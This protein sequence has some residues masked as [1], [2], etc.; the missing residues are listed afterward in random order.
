M[1]NPN[2]LAPSLRAS[3][4]ARFKEL[5]RLEPGIVAYLHALPLEQAVVARMPVRAIGSSYAMDAVVRYDSPGVSRT[6]LLHVEFQS[7]AD[8]RMPQ[9]MVLYWQLLLAMCSA[10][11]GLQQ[12]VLRVRRTSKM[13][14]RLRLFAG[15]RTTVEAKVRALNDYDAAELALAATTESS[16]IPLAAALIPGARGGTS[17]RALSDS[18]KLLC[19]QPLDPAWLVHV[20]ALHRAL[21]E[22]NSVEPG[23]WRE[24]AMSI[25]PELAAIHE[26]DDAWFAEELEDAMMERERR[27]E[28][29]GREAGLQDGIK[30]GIEQGMQRAAQAERAHRQTLLRLAAACAPDLVRTLE[31]VDDLAELEARVL[32]AVQR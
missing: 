25:N 6:L 19:A 24:V 2:P 21:A 15:R 13:P 27:G 26:D 3:L 12:L 23:L 10:D 28:R 22:L 5:C 1:P 11:E 31:A 18:L 8:A 20:T 17:R 14:T 4:D 32:Q 9:R 29:R 16:A 7:A 30:Q